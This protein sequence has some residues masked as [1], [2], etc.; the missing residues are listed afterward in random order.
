MHRIWA[1]G[2]CG[3]LLIGCSGGSAPG[4]ED[5]GAPSADA[6]EVS[7]L[8]ERVAG[9][10]SYDEAIAA[11][12]QEVQIFWEERYPALYGGPFTEVAELR[13]VGPGDD[14]E[15][16]DE[17]G[18]YRDVKGEALYCPAD[19]AILYDDATLFPDL[20]RDFGSLTNGAVLA[21]E[22]AHAVQRRS[23][24]ATSGASTIALELQA[25]CFA[26]SWV[27]HVRTG[28]DDLFDVDTAQ[29]AAALSGYLTLREQSGG[30]APAA[31][32]HG[33]AFDRVNA[34][35]EGFEQG[36]SRC[37]AYADPVSVPQLFGTPFTS[38]LDP[39]R[40]GS[41]LADVV[42]DVGADLNAFWV[43][44]IPGFEP[45]TVETIPRDGQV[46][47]GAESLRKEELGAP[48]VY[49]GTDRTVLY[50]EMAVGDFHERIG[51]GAIAAY[52]G[53]AWARAAGDA[54]GFPIAPDEFDLT[55][56]CLSGTWVG[57]LA[58]ERR[59]DALVDV[60]PGD[61]DEVVAA[62]VASEAL[63]GSER[64]LSAF[65]RVSAFRAGFLA[66]ADDESGPADACRRFL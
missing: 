42:D 16:G 17:R 32:T 63:R 54:L 3:A 28:T 34:L 51:D 20:H 9:N 26:G 44:R 58:A 13:A 22:W 8:G 30:V 5:A 12:R 1:L 29:L 62:L 43:G 50:D 11:A 53:D 57:D 40:A 38:Q 55:L 36:P 41:P 33:S 2:W 10:L 59:A 49:C 60:L 37:A 64:D 27:A 48:A 56:D 46:R 61:L 39:S 52:L 4:D 23:G 19:D 14:I 66:S 47:C 15:C 7:V 6:A 25:D 35:Q 24:L 65:E 45:V 21:H 31:S 18:S